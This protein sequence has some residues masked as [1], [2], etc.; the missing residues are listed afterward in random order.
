M[1][2]AEEIMATDYEIRGEY[3]TKA[4]ALKAAREQM[5]DSEYF[6]DW[7]EEHYGDEAL[8]LY[9]S[10]DAENYDNDEE[11]RI[12]VA[13]KSKF[14]AARKRDE[15]FLVKARA[16]AIAAHHKELEAKKA[17][18]AAAGKVHYSWPSNPDVDLPAQVEVVVSTD[19]TVKAKERKKGKKSSG[20]PADAANT[21]PSESSAAA[22]AA[23]AAAAAATP[24]AGVS[25]EE[26][27]RELGIPG[28]EVKSC[29]LESPGG[30]EMTA[31]FQTAVIT[32]LQGMESLEE[33]Y[34]H[35]GFQGRRNEVDFLGRLCTETQ[36]PHT[37]RVFSAP[38]GDFSP[39]C[40]MEM[41]KFKRLEELR[42]ESAI[43]MEHGLGIELRDPYDSDGGEDPDLPYDEAF[44]VLGMESESLTFMDL[45][46]IL[47][48]SAIKWCVN[49]D[50]LD[51]LSRYAGIEVELGEQ[52]H[53]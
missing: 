39:D 46:G 8:D 51:W 19:G 20:P 49:Y 28:N 44:R 23:T 24:D 12:Y 7:A 18:V 13:T 2:K 47:D 29:M 6:D 50:T 32:L 25:A 36:L 35:G 17:A 22:A 38:L 16:E 14:D 37:L 53:Y 15:D 48:F 10:A 3:E 5:L 45:S 31:Q 27:L 11:V 4:A 9:D 34:L 52:E 41:P 1:S 33:L 40:V 43:S 42:L 26:F 21:G 30:P